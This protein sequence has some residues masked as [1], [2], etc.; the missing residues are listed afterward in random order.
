MEAPVTRRPIAQRIAELE[1]RKRT[2]LTRLGKQERAV[3]TRRKILLGA[4]VF[5]QLQH[6]KDPVFDAQLRQWLRDELP[7]F[8]VRKNDREL[9][10]GDLLVRAHHIVVKNEEADR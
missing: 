6:A 8:L 7:G 5:H 4:F 10:E 1:A 9:F 2:L 3:D